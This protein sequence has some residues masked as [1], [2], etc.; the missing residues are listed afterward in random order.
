[1]RIYTRSGDKG[2][3]SLVYGQRV[4]K[5]HLRVEAYGTCDEVNSSIGLAASYIE[6]TNWDGKLAFLDQLQR[7]QTILFHVGAELSTPKDKEVYWK[8]E[9]KHI[10]EME[11][12][13]DEWDK[14]LEPLKNF[15]LPSGHRAASALHHA[16]TVARRAERLTVGLEDE[17]ENKLVLGYL[18]RLSDY[19][20]VAARYVNQ[21]LEGEEKHLHAD[22]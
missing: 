7:V 10:D 14:S 12:Q 9:Q 16:R 2:Q 22:V 17:V 15:I 18:N 19:L 8:L 5:N 20:F 21:Q 3:T 6:E 11:K 13:I 4:P 1:M